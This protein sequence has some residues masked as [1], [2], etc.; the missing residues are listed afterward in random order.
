MLIRKYTTSCSKCVSTS[1]WVITRGSWTDF[2][3]VNVTAYNTKR[4]IYAHTNFENRMC[5]YII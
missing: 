5:V 3:V 1:E 2:N 4:L